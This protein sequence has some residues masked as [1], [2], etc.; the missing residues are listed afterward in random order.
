ML[1]EATFDYGMGLLKQNYDRELTPD[2]KAI[3]LKYLS[4][5]L[6]DNQFLKAVQY[7]VL[8]SR[9]MPTAGQLVEFA[10]GSLEDQALQEWQKIV[11]AASNAQQPQVS[12]RALS[13]LAIIGGIEAVGYADQFTTRNLQQKFVKQYCKPYV[14][15]LPSNKPVEAIQPMQMPQWDYQGELA[16]LQAKL[17]KQKEVSEKEKQAKKSMPSIQ[18]IEAELKKITGQR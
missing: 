4:E 17:A 12:D 2:I 15:S 9:F 14:P 1:E 7:A 5:E 16:A 8:H 18:E 3:W 11:Q 10:K 6:S 13:A